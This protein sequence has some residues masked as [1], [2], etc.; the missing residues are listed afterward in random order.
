MDPISLI[1]GLFNF[2][3]HIDEHLNEIIQAY[4][5]LTYVILFFIIFA[6]TGFVVTPF[7]PGD[8]LLFASGAF[9]AL[10]SLNI[11]LTY[12]I[13]LAAAV[14]G[15]TANYWIGHFLGQK[16]I[17]NP[18]IPFINQ[19]HIDK[20]NAFY[21]KHGGKTIIL[22]R[23]VPIVRTFA[24]F[25]AGVGKMHYGKFI[26]YNI[27]GGILWVTLFTF[28]GFFFGNI[29]AVKHNFT[30]VI[31]VIILISVMPAVYEFLRHKLGSKEEKIKKTKI[32]SFDK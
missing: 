21:E 4:G 25:V 2:I 10:G 9:A 14:L 30:I 26:S 29:P 3:L 6:E 18:K 19:S 15:D 31:M 1:S 27:I 24:P 32:P 11:F 8:S 17:E 12:L 28:A 23:F 16:I 7:L 5:T 22:A 13:L 20:T